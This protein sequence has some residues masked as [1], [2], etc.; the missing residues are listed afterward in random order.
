MQGMPLRTSAAVLAAIAL[1]AGLIAGCSKSNDSGSSSSGAPLPDAAA[2][3]KQSS[4]FTK[5]QQSVHLELKADKGLQEKLPIETLSGDLTNVPAVAAQG[6]AKVVLGS[7]AVERE[8]VVINGD[9][10][11][12]L[13]KGGKMQNL[14][15]AK[16]VYDVSL[17]LNADTGLS[18]VLNNFSDPKVDGR[19]KVNGVEAVKITGKVSKDA[20]NAIAPQLE[21]TDA[22]PGTAW[23]REDGNHELLQAQLEAAQGSSVTMTTSDWGK[24]VTVNPPA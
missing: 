2:L 13:T 22:V 12:P 3:V 21:V 18:N 17:I 10:W 14:G 1:S 20:V 24:T 4:E 8:F 6:T 15:P 16:D 7:Q 9:L 23:I 19:Q 11:V 5:N